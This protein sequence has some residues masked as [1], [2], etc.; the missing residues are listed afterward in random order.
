MQRAS[1][2]KSNGRDFS[3]RLGTD[4]GS[5]PAARHAFEVWLRAHAVVDDDVHDM[6]VVV[7]ELASN[8]AIGSPAGATAQISATVSRGELRLEVSNEVD[9]ERAD[10]QHWDLEDPLRGGGRGLLIVRA[11]TD[12]MEVDSV[13]GT[14]TVRCARR[15]DVAS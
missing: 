9:P 4:A 5:I 15:L 14:V 12:T 7:S 3:W 2:S 8:A 13:G 10:V 11:Y 1:S 6:A